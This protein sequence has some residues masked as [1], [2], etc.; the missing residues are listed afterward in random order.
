MGRAASRCNGHDVTRLATSRLPESNLAH[1]LDAIPQKHYSILNSIPKFIGF[2]L[3]FLPFESAIAILRTQHK[4]T[5]YESTSFNR[6][7]RPAC[8]WCL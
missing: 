3:A 2:F 5:P 8:K 4:A 1:E 6:D 7:G